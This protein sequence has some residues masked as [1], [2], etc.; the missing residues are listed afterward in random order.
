[1]VFVGDLAVLEALAAEVVDGGLPLSVS[2][3]HG[4][5]SG[6]AVFAPPEFPYYGLA[7]L[8]DPGLS[9]DDPAL[10]RFVEEVRE[11]LAADDLG[12]TLLLPDDD[13]APEERLEALGLW[14]GSFLQA[15]AAGLAFLPES[16]GPEGAE[17]SLPE[18]LQEIV[19]DLAAIAEAD[20]Q[21]VEDLDDG[22]S[23]AE[24]QLV[25]LEEFVKVGVLLIMSVM[26]RGTA[27]PYE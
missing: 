23:D 11:D 6:F 26:S 22:E 20:P 5:V 21:S 9:G 24:A 19:S 25:E 2:A 14:C 15:F 17:F 27:D 1:M 12:F 4:A 3:L 7:D 10:A 13:I 16:S 8:L 18:E